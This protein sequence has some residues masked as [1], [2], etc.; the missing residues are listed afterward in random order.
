M[1]LFWE[2]LVCAGETQPGS[3]ADLREKPRRPLTSTL[4]VYGMN[5][6]LSKFQ[7]DEA[8]EPAHP[9]LATLKK[10]STVIP[11]YNEPVEIYVDLSDVTHG[12]QEKTV[13]TINEVLGLSTDDR[14]HI[15]QLL[16]TNA[17]LA[18]QEVDF[19]IS[20]GNPDH[21][22]TFENGISSVEEKIKFDGFSIDENDELNSRFAL[23]N[24]LPKWE[25]EHGVSI[26]IKNGKP[27]ALGD[28]QDDLVPFD[29]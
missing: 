3:R 7:I 6:L 14:K 17:K 15:Q 19:G 22:C 4:G 28:Y 9:S 10:M 16:F 24:I 13:Q 27:I 8:L 23:F 11:V 1:V 29:T 20:V 25:E 26:V 5:M 21:P 12:V 2:S 18:E